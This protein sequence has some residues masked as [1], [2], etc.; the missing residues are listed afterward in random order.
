VTVDRAATGIV[1]A[2]V[3]AAAVTTAAGAVDATATA[4][5]AEIADPEARVAEIVRI[6][7]AMRAASRSLRLPS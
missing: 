2:G 3:T 4:V 7:A 6:A 1:A 5:R